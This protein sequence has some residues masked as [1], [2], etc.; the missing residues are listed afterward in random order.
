MAVPTATYRLQLHCDFT[1]KNVKDIVA[2]LHEFGVST[3]YASPFFQSCKGSTHGYDVTVPQQINPEIGTLEEFTLLMQQLEKN[4]M[5]WL[6]DIVPNHVAWNWQ[7]PWL[8]DVLE[9]GQHSKY[10]SY[11]DIDWQHP[12]FHGKLIAPFLGSDLQDVVE[13]KEISVILDEEGLC[14]KYYDQLFP[15]SVESWNFLL[16]KISSENS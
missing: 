4:Q 6:Q 12:E 13:R 5:K 16:K 1:F 14:I 7:T 11:F 8:R 2:Y 15:L 9:R 10:A 3:I